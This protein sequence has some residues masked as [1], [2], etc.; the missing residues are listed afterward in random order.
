MKKKKVLALA[1]V[2]AMTIGTFTAC[3]EEEMASLDSF[4]EAANEFAEKYGD[5]EIT[6]DETAEDTADIKLSA[7][8]SNGWVWSELQEL[9]SEDMD[10]DPKQDFHLYVNKDWICESKIPDG[11]SGY[12]RYTARQ[13]DVDAEGLKLMTDDSLTGDNAKQVQ[14]IYSQLMDWD[15]REEVGYEPLEERLTHIESIASLDGLE[16]YMSDTSTTYND[17]LLEMAVVSDLNDSTRYVLCVGDAELIL[18]DPAEYTDRTE[19]GQRSYDYMSQMF[20]YMM[21]RLGTDEAEAQE[22]FDNAIAFETKLAEKAYTIEECYSDDIYDRINNFYSSDEL[23]ELCEV[24][25]MK[26][27][28]KAWGMKDQDRIQVENPDYIKNLDALMTEENLEGIKD[29]YIVNKTLAF[30]G[31]LDKAT[32]DKANEI[33]NEVYGVS[34]EEPYEEVAY[35][36]VLSLAPIQAQQLYVE[37]Y[38]SEEMKQLITDTCDQVIATYKEMLKDNDYLSEETIDA[39]IEKLDNM[40]IHALYPDKWQDVSDWDYTGL[41]LVEIAAKSGRD[42]VE[43]NLSKADTKVDKDLWIDSDVGWTVMQVNAFYNLNDNSINMILG[44]MG[45]PFYNEDMSVEEI[46]ASLGAFWIGHE[47]SHAFDSGGSQFDKDGNLANWWTEEDAAAF[48]E[49][50][51][52]LDAYLDSIEITDGYSVNGAMVDT[53]M[54]A[55]YTGLECALKMAEDIDDF[56][57]DKFF[58]TYAKMN[59]SISTEASEISNLLTDSHP[60]NFLRTNVPVQQFDEF[61]ETYDVQEGDAMYLAPEDRL[62]IW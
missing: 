22:I 7:T 54:A 30:A 17:S 15:E 46:Y 38:G 4:I 9:V 12:S 34:G 36:M 24:Y 25:P 13:Q 52:K 43:Y 31:L 48:Q 51:S 62:L 3:T 41:S 26:A 57:Y 50:I 2:S 42:Q 14:Y 16:A 39:A 5:E 10:T 27:V 60:L 8:T 33:Y 44:M 58:T 21:G 59:V 45:D 40:E 61:Y 11:Y 49:R 18:G 20:V 19:N 56:D 23:C 1:L 29:R 28:L 47:V 32:Y 53:E 37:Q 6:T 35:N 55:D